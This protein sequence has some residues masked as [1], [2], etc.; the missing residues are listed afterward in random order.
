MYLVLLVPKV[1]CLLHK[2]AF[3]TGDKFTTAC[4][5]SFHQSRGV[6]ASYV[7]M[8]CVCRDKNSAIYTVYLFLSPQFIFAIVSLKW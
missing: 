2:Q 6:F 8:G 5:G 4:F 1:V 7:F 3:I